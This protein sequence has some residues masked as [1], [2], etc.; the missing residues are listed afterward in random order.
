MTTTICINMAINKNINTDDIDINTNTAPPTQWATCT[1]VQVVLLLRS[2]SSDT[3]DGSVTNTASDSITSDITTDD[4]GITMNSDSNTINVII[5]DINTVIIV[6]TNNNI[7]VFSEKCCS[8]FS[9]FWL[10]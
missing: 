4:S 10:K 8:R 1:L 9:C 7:I 2:S 3:T 5:S 6:I